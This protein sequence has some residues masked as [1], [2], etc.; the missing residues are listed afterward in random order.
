MADLPTP[1]RFT[2]SVRNL[3]IATAVL[4]ADFAYFL[5]YLDRTIDWLSPPDQ[6]VAPLFPRL[7]PL[8]DHHPWLFVLVTAFTATGAVGGLIAVARSILP[9]TA[10]N[11]FAWN[12]PRPPRPSQPWPDDDFRAAVASGILALSG[13]TTLLYV[14]SCVRVDRS[15]PE[16]IVTWVEPL[17]LYVEEATFL[18]WLLS[19]LAIIVGVYAWVRFRTWLNLIAGCAVCLAIMNFVGT[20]YFMIWAYAD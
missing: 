12:P 5:P 7:K 18:G 20:L 14:T 6:P 2:T 1:P 15:F 3:L 19:A 16:P 9:G 13:T 11:R 8:Y 17:R 10:R 4:S